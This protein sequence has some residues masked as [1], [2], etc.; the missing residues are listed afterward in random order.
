[1]LCFNKLRC[2]ICAALSIFMEDDPV[3]FSLHYFEINIAGNVDDVILLIQIVLLLRVS[4]N[5][6]FC[7]FRRFPAFKLERILDRSIVL[8][9]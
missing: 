3:T 8:A 1:M 7:R 6:I 5:V 2:F 4:C 9:N